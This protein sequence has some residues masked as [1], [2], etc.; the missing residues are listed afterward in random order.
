MSS[1]CKLS[2]V[3]FRLSI[4]N[5]KPYNKSIPTHREKSEIDNP[6]YV[7]EIGSTSMIMD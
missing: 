1:R 2:M 7:I 6:H 3:D 5:G 4:A